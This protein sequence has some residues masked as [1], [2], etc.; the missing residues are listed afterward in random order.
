MG[1]WIKK[2]SSIHDDVQTRIIS[3]LSPDK[4]LF[5]RFHKKAEMFYMPCRSE[6]DLRLLGQVHRKFVI[7]L[8]YCPT[9][10]Q[11]REGVKKVGPY[12]R[13]VSCWPV[14]KMV[15]FKVS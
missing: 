7:D 15:M 10:A 13:M 5:H 8:K 6:L 3:T 14:V 4:N 12:N 1:T 2:D 9:D 11:N